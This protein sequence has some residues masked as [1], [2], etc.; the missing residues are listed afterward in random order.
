MKKEPI[1]VRLIRAFY[2]AFHFAM[3]PL[4]RL[5]SMLAKPDGIMAVPFGTNLVNS[6]VGAS[7]AKMADI[8]NELHAKFPHQKLIGQWEIEGLVPLDY[9]VGPKGS[10]HIT[11]R[12]FLEQVREK[13]PDLKKVT[14][15]A[16]PDHIFRVYKSARKLGFVPVVPEQVQQIPYDPTS[17]QLWCRYPWKM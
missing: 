1:I 3:P 17:I 11:T 4:T 2:Y 7:N 6:P 14:L 12:K 13:F 8:M 10:L 15:I 5:L 16:H 9:V